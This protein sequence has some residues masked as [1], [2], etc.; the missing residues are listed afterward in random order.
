MRIHCLFVSHRIL[1]SISSASST[2][3]S[4]QLY[5][6]AKSG[7]KGLDAIN[8][9]KS[10]ALSFPGALRISS[11]QAKRANEGHCQPETKHCI[12]NQT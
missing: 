1:L 12:N 10:S 11:A 2:R 7:F 3:A 5:G 4:V 9:T 8:P 6:A